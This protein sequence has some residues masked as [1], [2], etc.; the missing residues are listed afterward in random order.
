[1]QEAFSFKIIK[2]H[3]KRVREEPV[4]EDA[5]WGFI[6]VSVKDYRIAESGAVKFLLLDDVPIIKEDALRNAVTVLA[7]LDDNTHVSGIDRNSVRIDQL[8]AIVPD[9]GL[10]RA[11][12]E[13]AAD[14]APEKVDVIRG[15]FGRNFPEHFRIFVEI[16]NFF[17]IP[18]SHIT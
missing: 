4:H 7:R 10:G 17:E 15:A 2:F 5:A 3:E 14:K 1:M 11:L 16:F 8:C 13:G 9:R 12:P 6:P 18:F